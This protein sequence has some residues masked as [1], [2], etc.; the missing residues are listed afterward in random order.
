MEG[1]EREEKENGIEGRRVRRENR[2]IFE[3]RLSFC[4]WKLYKRPP[5]LL[6]AFLRNP[7]RWRDSIN[8]PLT[9]SSSFSFS[10][11][12]S[13]PSS[14]SSRS[15]FC[16]PSV[17]VCASCCPLPSNVSAPPYSL[18]PPL[19]ST[20]LFLLL[21][22]LH[23]RLVNIFWSLHFYLYFYFIHTRVVLRYTFVCDSLII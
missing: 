2:F 13:S 23:Y 6:L 10:F 15:L 3:I 12:S 9:L 1:K 8:Q 16:K 11:Y 5:P 4:A 22:T 18:D 7:P 14:S 17:P 21:H 19:V 20:N